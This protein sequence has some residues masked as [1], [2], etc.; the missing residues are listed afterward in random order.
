MDAAEFGLPFLDD[1][2]PAPTTIPKFTK[3]AKKQETA[4]PEPPPAFLQ[5]PASSF[6]ELLVV[7]HGRSRQVTHGPKFSPK[8]NMLCVGF[9]PDGTRICTG[10]EDRSARIYDISTGTE[11][12][13]RCFEHEDAVRRCCFSPDGLLLATA[14]YDGHA[15][16]FDIEG[17]VELK[18]LR[19]GKYVL[20]INFSP[21]GRF[22]CTSDWGKNV[23]VFL[24]EDWSELIVFRYMEEAG[25]CSFSADSKRLCTACSDGWARIHETPEPPEKLEDGTLAAGPK[26]KKLDLKS[27]KIAELKARLRKFDQEE[28]GRK[29]ELIDRLVSVGGDETPEEP[30]PDPFRELQAFEH[31]DKVTDARFNAS[32]EWLLTAC[33]D[34][35]ARVY[36]I[37]TGEVLRSFPHGNWIHVACFTFDSSCVCTACDDGFARVFSVGSEKELA[38]FAVGASLTGVAFSREGH[39]VATSAKATL[40][41]GAAQVWGLV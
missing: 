36:D 1:D 17:N 4:P 40:L 8:F 25:S 10:S 15:R 34:T 24:L 41:T 31:A 22:L 14:A 35:L 29:A 23:R 30:P 33:N 21:D 12:E 11:K 38:S 32:G 13:L 7:R 27:F 28:R 5:N 39:R 16:L 2:D 20:S 18:A 37:E 19:L 26:M 9:S 3:P 6:G